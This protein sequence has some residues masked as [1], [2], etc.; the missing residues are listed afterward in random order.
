METFNSF[1]NNINKKFSKIGKN[2]DFYE[3][4]ENCENCENDDKSER[5]QNCKKYEEY[6][7]QEN[8]RIIFEY[9]FYIVIGTVLLLYILFPDKM[10]DLFK[11]ILSSFKVNNK[12]NSKTNTFLYS[13]VFLTL[14][15]SLLL[16]AIN[17]WSLKSYNILLVYMIVII[18]IIIYSTK[19]C[20]TD[21]K[22]TY[23]NFNKE[24]VMRNFRFY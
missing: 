5:C 19:V 1:A 12:E 9:V 11:N 18:A 22:E 21:K 15:F 10:N 23:S 17:A 4:Y 3:N 14:L 2:T 20:F 6:V 8:K 7:E 24:V 13:I 16:T